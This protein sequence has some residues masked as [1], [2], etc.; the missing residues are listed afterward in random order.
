MHRIEVKHLFKP[1]DDELIALLESLTPEDWD[2]QTVAKAWKVKDVVAH[3][4]DGNIRLLSLQRDRYFGEQLPAINAY[5]D[6]VDWLN[7]LN[8]DWVAAAKRISPGVLILLLKATAD[9]CTAYYEALNPD[10]TAIFAVSWAG[11]EESLN[12]MHLAREYTE[13]WH[14]Q[15]QIREATGRD[16]VMTREY[17]YPVIDTFFRALPF[18]FKNVE[19][20]TGTIIKI[21]ITTDIGGNW[22]LQKQSDGW[23]LVSKTPTYQFDAT[24]SIPPQI[25]W[26]LFSKSIRPDEIISQVIITGD[27]N[28]AGQVLHMVSVM[29]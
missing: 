27:T 10:D 14:H 12:W 28:L 16:G 29:A 22:Y 26:K 8:G 18:T 1:L 5:Q 19:A 11:E 20:A 23:Q 2:K 6:L 15:Q 3:L 4:L 21:T 13:R 25:S 9:L 17:Y 24:V 7:K